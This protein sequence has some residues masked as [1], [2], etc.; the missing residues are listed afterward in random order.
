[1]TVARTLYGSV[2]RRTMRS[3]V[4]LVDVLIKTVRFLESLREHE[5]RDA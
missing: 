1:M 2:C 3:S 4:V 5:R